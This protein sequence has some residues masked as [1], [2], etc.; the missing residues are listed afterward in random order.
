VVLVHCE[1]DRRGDPA[2]ASPD[3]RPDRTARLGPALIYIHKQGRLIAELLI[4]ARLEKL[5]DD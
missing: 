2:V 4:R 5:L 1:S 3:P